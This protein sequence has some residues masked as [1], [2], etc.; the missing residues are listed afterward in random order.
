MKT[1]FTFLLILMLSGLT[2][3]CNADNKSLPGEYRTYKGDAS[4]MLKADGTA[5]LRDK[6]VKT[7]YRWTILYED[8]DCTRLQMDPTEGGE[9]LMPCT[10]ASLKG[11][12]INLRKAGE[13]EG[14]IFIRK[15]SK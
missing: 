5:I 4:L 12:V 7:P 11:P 13:K 14:R 10:V 15:T 9:I 1:I 3:A 2:T 6:G 8:S